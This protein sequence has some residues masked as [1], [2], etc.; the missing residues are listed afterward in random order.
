MLMVMSL[1]DSE[2]SQHVE[3]A[4]C[5]RS[6]KP[7]LREH[8]DGGYIAARATVL[9]RY[10]LV[11]SRVTGSEFR[12]FNL[13]KYIDLEQLEYVRTILEQVARG[14][15]NMFRSLTSS[16]FAHRRLNGMESYFYNFE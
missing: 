10:G 14:K 4:L 16:N 2:S 5:G 1:I 7:S 6:G 11:S 15:V 8:R 12:H 3:H 9:R 13:L